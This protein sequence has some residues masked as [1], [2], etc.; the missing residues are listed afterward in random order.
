MATLKFVRVA[1]TALALSAL[2]GA[3]PGLARYN[4][5]ER[6]LIKEVVASGAASVTF[7]AG[8]DS[9]YSVYVVEYWKV[10]SSSDNDYLVMEAATGC[11]SSCSWQGGT[12]Y[13]YISEVC[14]P[15]GTGPW[16]WRGTGAASLPLINPSERAGNAAGEFASGWIKVFDPSRSAGYKKFRWAGNFHFTDGDDYSTDGAG[17]LNSAV[18][19]NGLR[20]SFNSGNIDGRFRLFG[21]R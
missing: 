6:V 13:D 7:D 15:D 17:S 14:Y 5:V 10:R 20:F 16:W 18:A 1:V 11:P 19:I 2:P 12:L 8:I 3:T 21:I 4:P 9:T